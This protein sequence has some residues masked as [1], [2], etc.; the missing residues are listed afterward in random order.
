[1]IFFFFTFPFE[2]LIYH[3]FYVRVCAFV[4]RPIR[5]TC[6]FWNHFAHSN[7]LLLKLILSSSQNAVCLYVGCVFMSGWNTSRHW[8]RSICERMA[9]TQYI[10]K[11]FR[12]QLLINGNKR[13]LLARRQRWKWEY[14]HYHYHSIWSW[15]ISLNETWSEKS[16]LKYKKATSETASFVTSFTSMSI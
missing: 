7:P 11:A 9:M 15:V 3:L 2:D 12:L 8:W 14:D 5:D 16:N 4:C 6:I 1:M 10:Y 13:Y